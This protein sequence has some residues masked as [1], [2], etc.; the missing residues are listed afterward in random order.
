ME[1]MREDLKHSERIDL[2]LGEGHIFCYEQNQGGKFGW[3]CR[4][5]CMW[6]MGVCGK[7]RTLRDFMGDGLFL[8]RS[9][10]DRSW[11]KDMRR[12]RDI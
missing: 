9:S 2:E 7:D 11:V 10:A 5:V 8:A 4:E 3:V 12:M 1:E 6:S